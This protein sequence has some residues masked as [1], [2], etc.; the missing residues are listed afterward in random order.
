MAVASLRNDCIRPMNLVTFLFGAATWNGDSAQ[1][2]W[3]GRAELRATQRRA[4]LRFMADPG[5][6]ASNIEP[7]LMQ[8]PEF[9]ATIAAYGSLLHMHRAVE[10][11]TGPADAMVIKTAAMAGWTSLVMVLARPFTDTEAR[12]IAEA[13]NDY[14]KDAAVSTFAVLDCVFANCNQDAFVQVC[15]TQMKLL[16]AVLAAPAL[17]PCAHAIVTCIITRDEHQHRVRDLLIEACETGMGDAVIAR[18][19]TALP[20]AMKPDVTAV[21]II[22]GNLGWLYGVMAPPMPRDAYALSLEDSTGR[23]MRVLAQHRVRIKTA[24]RTGIADALER[25]PAQTYQFIYR[26][27]EPRS[28]LRSLIPQG[29]YTQALMLNAT[30]ELTALVRRRVPLDQEDRTKLQWFMELEPDMITMFLAAHQAEGVA[31]PFV[32]VGGTPYATA[33][34]ADSELPLRTLAAHHTPFGAEDLEA[35]SFAVSETPSDVGLLQRHLGDNMPVIPHV[36]TL[37]YTRREPDYSIGIVG[38]PVLR[39]RLNQYTAELNALMEAD[40]RD[41]RL[42]YI[43]RGRVPGGG[44]RLDYQNPHPRTRLGAIMKRVRTAV[45]PT[46]W[47]NFDRSK[48]RIASGTLAYVPPGCAAQSVHADHDDI[49]YYYTVIVQLTRE[50]AAG[51]TRFEGKSPRY[52]PVSC[53]VYF[54]NG[55]VRHWGP[56]HRGREVR[57][58]A[59]FVI[60]AKHDRV[61]DFNVDPE[62][63]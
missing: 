13:M 24:D 25:E 37:T 59:A 47:Q 60:R 62:E 61:R 40:L 50:E 29:P 32:A 48:D 53:D 1:H 28:P 54:F 12:V 63:A 3:R 9:Q 17:S 30:E 43:S 5:A 26:H 38:D 57:W 14:C 31:L 10:A 41:P 20:R 2:L 21:A 39:V 49:S 34:C 22:H 46:I 51:R 16:E 8:R 19:H 56:E 45:E 15:V 58:F 42:T 36:A 44:P 27:S 6:D 33:L 35:L 52:V 18:I 7:W 4:V 55:R 11:M 23:S